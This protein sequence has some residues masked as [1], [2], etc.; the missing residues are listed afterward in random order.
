MYFTDSFGIIII[1]NKCIEYMYIVNTIMR[2]LSGDLMK[3]LFL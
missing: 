1:F 2:V 3:Y